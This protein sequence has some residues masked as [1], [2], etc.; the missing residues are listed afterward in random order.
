MISWRLGSF[1]SVTELIAPPRSTKLRT[2]TGRGCPGFLRVLGDFPD[3]RLV[4]LY[5]LAF[6]A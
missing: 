5:N 6:A 1:L 3:E 4:R 2:A